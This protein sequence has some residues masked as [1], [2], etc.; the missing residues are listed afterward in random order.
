MFKTFDEVILVKKEGFADD[1]LTS[2]I[3][4]F[5]SRIGVVVGEFDDAYVVEY[6]PVRILI[7]GKLLKKYK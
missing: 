5:G 2:L 4:Y 1:L 6:D 3:W 7:P